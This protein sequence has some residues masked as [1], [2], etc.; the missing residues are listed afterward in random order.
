MR[1]LTRC[2][3]L[4]IFFSSPLFATPLIDQLIDATNQF[5]EQEVQEHIART[6]QPGRYEIKLNRLDARLRLPLCPEEQLSAELESP[7]I[8]VGRV[9]V[10]LTC[11]SDSPWRLF[12][13]GQVS[14][15]QQVLVSAH[16]LSRDTVLSA[17]DL[18]LQERDT[19][20][21][22][23]KY[24][25]EPEQAIGMRLTRPVAPDT[26]VTFAIIAQNEVI[27]RGDKVV[28]SASNGSVSVKMPGEAMEDGAVGAQIRV[29]NTRSNR[30]I[31]A[32]VSA[33]G[34]VRVDM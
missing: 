5:L 15:Y 26:I 25:V 4:T 12:V 10:R 11:N 33:A 16:P 21:L 32:R 29:R 22:R 13:P 6:G 9:T 20:L 34:Q 8:P 30:E 7:N 19:S 1:F 14:L 31:K 24:L 3:A 28:I 18:T 27:R 17:S 23:D 2:A